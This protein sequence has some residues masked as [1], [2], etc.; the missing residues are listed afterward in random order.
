L[1]LLQPTFLQKS[2][3]PT[4]GPWAATLIAIKS[5]P[6]IT[7]KWYKH[8]N[9][10]IILSWWSYPQGLVNTALFT[11]KY[12][13]LLKATYST[14]LHRIFIFICNPLIFWQL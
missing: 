10:F 13:K 11:S 5:H 3:K 7:Y 1:P 6:H 2:T 8:N 12:N 4:S 14:F 9:L